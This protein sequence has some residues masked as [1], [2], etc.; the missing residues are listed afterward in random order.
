MTVD[1]EEWYRSEY[2]RLVNTIALATGDRS[3]A[4]DAASEACVRALARW[5]RVS[6][7]TQPGGWVYKVALN[8]AR[9]RLRKGARER[10]FMRGLAPGIDLVA[11]ASEP[12]HDLWQAVARLPQR[13]REAVVLRYVADLTEPAIAR[14][15]GVRRGTV[16]TMLRR[17]NERLAAELGSRFTSDDHD[18]KNGAF[19][20]AFH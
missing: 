4:V 9:R 2:P 1:F 19:A 11:P 8:D 6:R 10:E 18:D 12:D 7:M 20:H 15:L 14:T 16:A 13:T 3:V 17:A 5:D